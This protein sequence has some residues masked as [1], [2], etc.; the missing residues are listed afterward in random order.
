MLKIDTPLVIPNTCPSCG[1]DTMGGQYFSV[2]RQFH[3]RV[4]N[5]CGHIAKK[6]NKP[7]ES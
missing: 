4:C 7:K 1:R 6:L 5:S 3:Y 2:S